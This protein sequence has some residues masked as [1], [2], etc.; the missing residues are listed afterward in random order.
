M[1]DY[2]NIKYY[3]FELFLYTGSLILDRE[4]VYNLR[5]DFIFDGCGAL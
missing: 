5:T 3:E 2:F 1:Y 4:S